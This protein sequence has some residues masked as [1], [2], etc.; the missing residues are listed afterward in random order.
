[1]AP[2]ATLQFDQAAFDAYR[3]GSDAVITVDRVGDA[4]LAASVAYYVSGGTAIDGTDYQAQ[5]GTLQFA[6]CATTATISLP[7]Y[8]NPSAA[9]DVTVNLALSTPTGNTT[10]VH[11]LR[12]SSPFILPTTSSRPMHQF[13]TRTATRG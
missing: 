6:P 2:A 3:N 8:S 10:L 1:M 5:S 12:R 7:V 9:G 11:K 4:T 13:S